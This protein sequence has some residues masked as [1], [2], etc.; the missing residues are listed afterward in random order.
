MI[1]FE[2][3]CFSYG[4]DKKEVDLDSLNLTIADGEII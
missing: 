4:R 2:D 3:V 1:I